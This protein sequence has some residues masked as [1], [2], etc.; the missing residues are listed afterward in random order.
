MREA[1]L[2]RF[3]EVLDRAAALLPPSVPLSA[4]AKRLYFDALAAVS[5]ETFQ[6]ALT[7]HMRDP[8]RGRFFPRPADILAQ[9]AGHDTRPD[10]DEAWALAV[11]ALDET[12]TV[13][14]TTEM[15]DAWAIA[16]AVIDKGND[17][18]GARM[19]FKDAYAR[20]STEARRDGRP[21]AWLVS[22]GFDQRK[23]LLAVETAI[24]QGRLSRSQA[25]QLPLYTEQPPLL[26]GASSG[27]TAP[28]EHRERLAKLREFFVQKIAAPG[29]D[30]AAKLRTKE[31]QA[32]LATKVAD[33]A[34]KGEA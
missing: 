3:A 20:L 16:R 19:A 15:Q 28:A 22:E 9:I 11:Q 14:W 5:I 4:E 17:M 25:P 2:R 23:R 6:A 32:E 21:P 8:D 27:S 29:V 33:Y 24:K 12:N 1:D 34:G 13:V 31:L 10:A 26:D 7:A 30:G 18:V